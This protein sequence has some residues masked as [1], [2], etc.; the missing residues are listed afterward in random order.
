MDTARQLGNIR[1][2]LSTQEFLDS[3]RISCGTPP[4]GVQLL[5]VLGKTSPAATYTATA[6]KRNGCPVTIST[7]DLT[8]KNCLLGPGKATDIAKCTSEIVGNS[9]QIDPKQ[10][11]RLHWTV[12]VNDIYSSVTKDCDICA[13]FD[14]INKCPT[15]YTASSPCV[16]GQ[17]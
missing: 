15:P 17:F 11:G 4:S 1:A 2:V 5:P 9:V 10:E 7:S 6:S 8:C 16:L 14:A 12:T 3:S 13:S